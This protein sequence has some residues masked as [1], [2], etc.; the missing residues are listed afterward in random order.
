[1]GDHLQHEH[2]ELDGNWIVALC[3]LARS[4]GAS[5]TAAGSC[6]RGFHVAVEVL[7]GGLNAGL[8]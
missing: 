5:G 3:V 1:M 2:M 8:Q 4:A 7:V 6:A